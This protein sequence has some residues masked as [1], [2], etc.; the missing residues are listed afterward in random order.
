MVWKRYAQTSFRKSEVQ[1]FWQLWR[2]P[3]RFSARTTSRPE[4]S[5]GSFKPYANLDRSRSGERLH[6]EQREQREQRTASW[7][8]E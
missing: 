2:N 5:R 1:P 3:K 4:R 8:A 6:R 7:I